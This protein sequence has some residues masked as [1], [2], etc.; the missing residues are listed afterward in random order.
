MQV[1]LI[2]G[3]IEV[4]RDMGD[5]IRAA[6]QTEPVDLIGKTDLKQLLAL[7]RR[8]TALISPDSG[9]VHMGTA[10]GIPVIGLYATTNPDRAGP[11]LSQHWR[12]DRYPDAMQKFNQ[13]DAASA[14]WGT[15]VRNPEAMDLIMVDDVTGKL[16]EL[17]QT[18]KPASR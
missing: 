15:R 9:P 4:E 8:A 5:R 14:P 7:L 1:I 3:P 6:M 2:G 16:D 17:L 10:A 13:Q 18:Q 11:Y 12:V